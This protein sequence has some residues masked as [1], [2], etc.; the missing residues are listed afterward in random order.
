[1][2]KYDWSNVPKEVEYLAIDEGDEFAYGFSSKPSIYHGD[3]WVGDVVN[4]VTDLC[5]TFDGNWRDSLEQRPN[6]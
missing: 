3:M 1:M 2:N 6:G 4:N 5:L